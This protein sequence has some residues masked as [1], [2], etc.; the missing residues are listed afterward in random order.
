MTILKEYINSLLEIRKQP[1]DSAKLIAGLQR[2]IDKLYASPKISDIIRQKINDRMGKD[3]D[4]EKNYSKVEQSYRDRFF[5]VK[6]TEGNY[7]MIAFDLWCLGIS[8]TIRNDYDEDEDDPIIEVFENIV[9]A[10]VTRYGWSIHSVKQKSG[11]LVIA[12]ERIYG[13]R[14]ESLPKLLYHVTPCEN[15]KRIL[16][17]GLL[18]KG[19]VK[20][21]D[22]DRTSRAYLPKIYLSKSEKLANELHLSFQQDEYA[23]AMSGG[24]SFGDAYVTLIIDTLNL[25]PGTKFYYDAEFSGTK[26][27]DDAIWTY[28]PVPNIA[29]SVSPDE[30]ENYKKFLEYKDRNPYEM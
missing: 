5:K 1:V 8:G 9:R 18:P 3:F 28:T 23:E 30:L 14:V 16:R 2:E 19:A 25:R 6:F 7:V 29:I 10:V 21:G 24:G 12:C 22:A 27:Q 15:V 11:N 4:Q 20:K 17:R 13:D 26:F